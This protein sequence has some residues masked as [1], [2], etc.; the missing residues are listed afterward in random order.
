MKRIEDRIYDHLITRSAGVPTVDLARLFFGMPPDFAGGAT[1]I[2]DT[3]LEKDPRFQR[4][5]DGW[6]ATPPE[7]GWQPLTQ[8]AWVVLTAPPPTTAAPPLRFLGVTEFRP[9]T[10]TPFL[11]TLYV[12]GPETAARQAAEELESRE[13][14]SCIPLTPL[15]SLRLLES[16]FSR[17]DLFLRGLTARGLGW[18]LQAAE[19]TGT[20]QPESFFSLV[21]MLRL[22]LPA[23]SRPGS[24]DDIL[25]VYG[26]SERRGDPFLTELDALPDILPAILDQLNLQG[27][28]RVDELT[29][30]LEAL[31]ESLDLSDCAF[32]RSDLERLPE[33]L[34]IYLLKN[35]A[36]E[37]IYI[38][39]SLNL[40]RRVSGYF[41]W[42]EESDPKLR[43]IQTDTRSLTTR[44]TGSDLEALLEEARLISQHQ[45]PIN[46][47]MDVHES[48][49]EKNLQDPLLVLLPHADSS[50]AALYGLHPG[51][52]IQRLEL[53]RRSPDPERLTSFITAA[54]S[55]TA[56]PVATRYEPALLPLALRW[57]RKNSHRLT[58]FRPSDYPGI[59]DVA[60]AVTRALPE[61]L[62]DEKKIF[63]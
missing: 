41:R 62:F 37:I 8:C 16:L 4:T 42:R 50:R 36:G 32:S 7:T 53:E 51:G 56:Q 31:R 24:L 19:E 14:R 26:I 63:L 2:V 54:V 52:L 45:P 3:V 6:T 13:N 49:H 27:I 28:A 38:G 39:K 10:E 15:K 61:Q 48:P 55:G 17:P 58:F 1:R 9:G 47:Q 30:R 11:T 57:L 29:T 21:D 40:R 20:S 35:D 25:P 22:V 18:F 12:S 5:A 44:E 43:R 33:T 34:G 23:E 59:E 46:V 60:R